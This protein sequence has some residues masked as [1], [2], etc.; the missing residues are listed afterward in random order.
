MSSLYS[1][2]FDG[3]MYAHYDFVNPRNNRGPD[4]YPYSFDTYFTWRP[5]PDK[6]EGAGAIYSDRMREWDWEKAKMAFKDSGSTESMKPNQAKRV[7]ELYYDG[8]YECVGY[9]VACNQSSGYPI[10]VFYIKE[11]V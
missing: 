2:G 6:A 4:K 10:G 8:K 7:I 11:R 9:A 3:K 5:D 1:Y